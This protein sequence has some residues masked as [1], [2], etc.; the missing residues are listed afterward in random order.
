MIRIIE[1]ISRMC[2]VP[3][4]PWIYSHCMLNIIFVDL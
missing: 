2:N 1:K 4:H 3:L